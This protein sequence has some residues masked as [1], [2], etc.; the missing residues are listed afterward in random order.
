MRQPVVE[1]MLRHINVYICRYTWFRVEFKVLNPPLYWT[2]GRLGKITMIF[3]LLQGLDV[4]VR[5][6]SCAESG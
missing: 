4:Q 3:I 2:V 6:L 1:Q 5:D